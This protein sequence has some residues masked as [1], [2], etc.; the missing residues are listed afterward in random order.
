M[1]SMTFNYSDLHFFDKSGTELMLKHSS[2]IKI[3]V[4]NDDYP[5][6]SQSYILIN[7]GDSSYQNSSLLQTKAG[8]RFKQKDKYKV[9]LTVG[10]EEPIETMVPASYF[11]ITEYSSSKGYIDADG[12]IIGTLETSI[13]LTYNDLNENQKRSFMEFIGLSDDDM[14]SNTSSFEANLVFDKVSTELVETQ[15]IF[16]LTETEDSYNNV[17]GIHGL[18]DASTN[19]SNN[20]AI[21]EFINKYNLFFFIDCRDQKDFR[22]FTIDG[23]SAVW[24]DRHVVDF[25]NGRMFMS[26]NGYRVDIGFRGELEGVYEQ[27]MYVCLLDKT[28]SEVTAIGTINMTAE[29]EGEDERYRT[30]FT[31]FGIPPMDEFEPVFRDSDINDEYPDYVARNRHAKKIFLSYSEIFPFAGSYKA[32]A[33]AVNLLGYNDLF[34]KEWYK[35]LGKKQTPDD[36]GYIAY[37]ISFKSNPKMNT[38][39][40]KPI[41]ERIQLRKMNWLSMMYRLNEE[42]DGTVDKWG[43]PNTKDNINYYNTGNLAKL[44]SLKEWLDKYIVGVNC[45]IT[46]VGGE[47]I[48]FERYSVYKFGQFQQIFDYTNERALSLKVNDKTEVIVDGSANI[49]VDVNT[50]NEYVKFEDFDGKTFLE[51]SEGVF[52]ENIYKDDSSTIISA[53]DGSTNTYFGKTFELYNHM[54]S[55]DI[56]TRGYHN[57]FKFNNRFIIN[58]YPQLIVDDDRIF[59]EPNDITR[60]IKSS[61]FKENSMPVIKINNGFIKRYNPSEYNKGELYDFI[62]IQKVGSVTH[63]KD[64]NYQLDSSS[65]YDIDGDFIIVPS[66]CDA[67][68]SPVTHRIKFDIRMSDPVITNY[69]HI[70]KMFEIDSSTTQ[71]PILYDDRTLGLR[72]T[73]DTFDGTPAFVITGYVSPQIK[74]MYGDFLP[75]QNETQEGEVYEYYLEILDGSMQFPDTFNDR[76]VSLNFRYDGETRKIDVTTFKT[77]RT[78]NIYEYET[79]QHHDK[80]TRFRTN[81]TYAY[82]IENYR[83]DAESVV[84]MNKTKLIN[85]VNTGTYS[86]DAVISDESNNMFCAKANK[87]VNVVT[88]DIDASLYT[89]DSS[90]ISTTEK[91]GTEIGDDNIPKINTIT[92]SENNRCIYEYVPKKNILSRNGLNIEIGGYNTKEQNIDNGSEYYRQNLPFKYMQIS[93]LSE[94]Y[95]LV[96]TYSFGGDTH[97]STPKKVLCFIKRSFIDDSTGFISMN[98]NED[99]TNV[100]TLQP[101]VN[102]GTILNHALIDPLLTQ[103]D[104]ASG[105]NIN[106][107]IGTLAN[108]N[109]ILYDDS[110]EYPICSYPG[111]CISIKNYDGSTFYSN[112]EY[113]VI[114]DSVVRVQEI[115]EFVELAQLSSTGIY[116]IP[117][118]ALECEVSGNNAISIKGYDILQYPFSKP[119]VKD[120][121]YKLMFITN[122][123][124]PESPYG[125]N[126]DVRHTQ[127]ASYGEIK[128]IKNTNAFGQSTYQLNLIQNP[129][130]HGYMSHWDKTLYLDSSLNDGYIDNQSVKIFISHAAKDYNEFILKTDETNTDYKNGNLIMNNTPVNR[131]VSYYF[132]TTYTVSLRNFH[133]R[134]GIIYWDDDSSSYID[135]MYSYD[136]NVVTSN[137]HIMIIPTL[138][139]EFTHYSDGI[140]IISNEDYTA[141]WKIYK[142]KNNCSHELLFECFNKIL[143]LNLEDLGTYDIEMTIYDEHGNKFERTFI[144]AITIKENE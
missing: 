6:C 110:C 121:C 122:E 48:V 44:I 138:S 83:N 123:D 70:G 3:D 107:E 9:I 69:K 86:L 72:F 84:F 126:I 101:N 134:N 136:C 42:I 73:A 85:V 4:P 26:D 1:S 144:G 71:T 16:I 78:S 12:N 24:S 31:N 115:D 125:Y 98:D 113:R 23:D 82:F 88:P 2:I 62:S 28:T 81:R 43:F 33:N 7:G 55:F 142:Q 79:S 67:K 116:I 19:A 106:D 21:Y 100:S 120:D 77:C 96:S 61:V 133:V 95:A 49:S 20:H 141:R 127:D 132:D 92:S 103:Y 108:V 59:F 109:V 36:D 30:F 89:C 114:F 65:S 34:F 37:D 112:Y 25:S 63:I 135:G 15:S 124:I 76:I 131:E 46:D 74:K 139:N 52:L 137:P 91:S 14:S 50:S 58:S 68:G 8:S 51:M 64:V 99:L 29:T 143:T 104:A 17:F 105:S 10:D 11:K 40:S 97:G 93:N 47:G 87:T 39:N 75:A 45:R 118:W 119:F 35:D 130:P 5:T 94:R 111:V 38:I 18:V 90:F 22:F 80:I 102:P 57:T 60:K 128:Q 66:K 41:E 140:D 117:A 32:L 13:D 54:D 129:A 53:G 27:K 56:R